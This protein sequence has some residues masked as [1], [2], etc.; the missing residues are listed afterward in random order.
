M[1]KILNGRRCSRIVCALVVLSGGLCTAFG[2]GPPTPPLPLDKATGGRIGGG[3]THLYSISL[4]AGAV[5]RLDVKEEGV[6]VG[7][8]LLRLSDRQF[9]TFADLNSGHGRETLT[10][11]AES[12]GDYQVGFKAWDS[13]RPGAYHFTATTKRRA[14]AA[15]RQ[16]V[17]A[18]RLS[19]EG[20]NS[21]KDVAGFRNAVARWEEAL[22]LWRALGDAYW[23]GYVT[24]YLGVMYSDLGEK[25]K[26]LSH[27]GRALRLW[28]AAGERRGEAV[29]LN[30]IG[31]AY[32]KTGEQARA[33]DYFNRALTLRLALGDEAEAATTLN[34]LGVVSDAIGEKPRALEYYG[35]ALSLWRAAGDREQ[36][37]TALTNTGLLYS[38]MGEQPQALDH[39]AQALRIRRELGD[40]VGEAYALNNIGATYERTGEYAAAL[41]H[42]QQALPLYRA[43]GDRRGEGAALNNIGMV[44]GALGEKTKA[45]DY[46]RQALL[47]SRAINSKHTEA[48][49][50]NN[51]GSVY[52]HLDEKEKAIEYYRQGLLLRRAIGDKSGEAQSLSNLS[53][54]YLRLDGGRKAL[55]YLNEALPLQRAAG[56]LSGEANTLS[57][58]GVAYWNLGDWAKAVDH[59]LRA[60]PLR[61]AAGDK[62]G[63]A[64]TLG[65]LMLTWES[66]GDRRMA[67]AVGKLAVETYQS[68]R[69]SARPLDNETQKSFHR[70]AALY[71]QR[72]A[73]LLMGERRLAEA[74]KVLI[75]YRDQQ[76]FDFGH[77][78]NEP[79]RPI[80]LTPRELALAARYERE[81]AAVVAF[82]A[83]LVDLKRQT[84]N[85]LPT[86]EEAARLSRLEAQMR[87]AT[88]AFASSF[89]RERA[90]FG[91]HADDRDGVVGVPE[92]AEMQGALRELEDATKQKTVALYT[93]VGAESFHLLLVSPGAIRH[94]TTPVGAHDLSRKVLQFY[95]LLQTPAYDP[96]PVGRQLYG[97]I[98]KPA[99]AELRAAGVQTLLWSLDNVLRYVPMAALSPDGK[100]YLVERFRNQVFTRA[101]RGR[102]TRPVSASWTG[103]GFA[104][105]R[106][107]TV[108]LLGDGNKLYF[109]ALPG[110]SAEMEAIFRTGP[111]A[112]GILSG[113]VIADA[114]FTRSAFYEALKRRRPLVHISSHFSFRPGDDSRSFLLLGDGTTLTLGE[115]KKEAGLFAGVEL[116][117]LSACNTAALRADANGREIDGFAELAQRLGAGAVLATLWA[118]ADESTPPLMREFYRAREG[119]AGVT[120]AEA[121]R[122]AQLALLEG[123]AGSEPSSAAKA[124][125]AAPRVMAEVGAGAQ[126]RTPEGADASVVRV[127][128]DEAP[129]FVA[130]RS[131]PLAHPFYW[132]PFVLIGNG[133]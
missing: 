85:R 51:L 2:Q 90:E 98:L 65:N 118:A 113:E 88:G 70:R 71:Y 103:V 19:A 12:G 44:Y 127:R 66:A 4:P 76:F 106:E 69:R 41:S 55:G 84:G 97:L 50:L 96:R 13:Q 16:R 72:L 7:V 74:L 9:V 109:Q 64:A 93:L 130:V 107:H 132:S 112:R 115:M 33:L 129:P 43:A 58:M 52:D 32:A 63:E 92:A 59:H 94:Y 116:L 73:E 20:L 3:E 17:R 123:T 31:T 48:T 126:G 60:L 49:A 28:K 23:E 36:E 29:T 39:Y 14:T 99:E 101:D 35:R 27:Y 105:S 46:F 108:D 100:G 53:W 34:N 128:P 30:N 42:F 40:K 83:E 6:D 8:G 75:L 80:P 114:E 1:P 121:L 91:K 124:A 54:V 24:N 62:D 86:G 38:S 82:V 5:L 102:L 26:A 45:R 104:A 18:E 11:V 120:K 110:A 117:S 77:D 61:R 111:G 87:E 95:A 56:D 131:R 122:R 10:Y 125:G 81:G 67:V 57:L 68:L 79:G 15:D 21:E 133:R 25:T 78:L 89:E 37:A 22:P 119:G 47:L